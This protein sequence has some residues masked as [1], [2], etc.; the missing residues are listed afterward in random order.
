MTSSNS[1]STGLILLAP[2]VYCANKSLKTFIFKNLIT[3][4]KTRCIRKC[5]VKYARPTANAF[6]YG[7]YVLAKGDPFLDN[8]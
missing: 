5:K 7:I 6:I 1:V 3:T 8:I 2:T 4:N